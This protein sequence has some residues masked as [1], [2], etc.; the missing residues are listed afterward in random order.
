LNFAYVASRFRL[1][2]ER[3]KDA[4]GDLTV[5]TPMRAGFGFKEGLLIYFQMELNDS[6]VEMPGSRPITRSSRADVKTGSNQ[7]SEVIKK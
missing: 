6:P 2:P 3:L 1:S 4:G 5:K 7:T